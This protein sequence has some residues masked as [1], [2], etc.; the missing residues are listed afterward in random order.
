[1]NPRLEHVWWSDPNTVRDNPFDWMDQQPFKGR[2]LILL[3]SLSLFLF[4]WIADFWGLLWLDPHQARVGGERKMRCGAPWFPLP[5]R[6]FRFSFV[7]LSWI[8]SDFRSS[9]GQKL[10]RGKTC[11]EVN[12]MKYDPN[13]ATAE[14]GSLQCWAAFWGPFSPQNV[15]PHFRCELSGAITRYA[16]M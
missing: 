12:V 10:L 14:G 11:W 4:G 7:W 13:D 3:G 6:H 8:S 9:F 16:D 1:M 5:P 2:F 15:V